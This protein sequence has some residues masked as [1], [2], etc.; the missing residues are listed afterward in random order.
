[1]NYLTL[2]I[3]VFRDPALGNPALRV[4]SIL[5]L[6]PKK[7]KDSG[8]EYIIFDKDNTFTISYEDA[9]FNKDIE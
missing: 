4:K 9:Y 8:I 6:N 2:F 1:M 7:L 3:K 5:D